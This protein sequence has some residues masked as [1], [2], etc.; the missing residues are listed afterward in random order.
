MRS[1]RMIDWYVLQFDNYGNISFAEGVGRG[2]W[3]HSPSPIGGQIVVLKLSLCDVTHFLFLT[4]SA[5][6]FDVDEDAK[7]SRKAV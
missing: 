5:E 2:W 7:N 6:V 3:D 1:D 4:P